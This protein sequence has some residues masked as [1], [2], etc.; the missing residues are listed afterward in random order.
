MS[1]SHYHCTQMLGV[2]NAIAC[3]MMLSASYSLVKEGAGLEDDEDCMIKSA[4]WRVV[5]GV[6]AGLMFILP[7]KRVLD[8]YEVS[9]CCY[10][11]CC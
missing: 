9:C 2:S 10:H 7:T 6:L 11:Y 3:G 4:A 1:R 5:V 8:R